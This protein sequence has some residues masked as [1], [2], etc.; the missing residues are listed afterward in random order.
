MIATLSRSGSGSYAVSN[1]RGYDVWGS[2]RSGSAS[3]YPNTR[4]CAN[5]GH[6]QDDES[7]LLY[8][9]AR[10]YEPW[11]GR[12]VT[13][14]PAR[15][16]WN[17][18]VYAGNEPATSL[19]PD[20]SN[21]VSEQLAYMGDILKLVGLTLMGYAQLDKTAMDRWLHALRSAW[22]TARL[23]GDMYHA[24]IIKRVIYL[25]HGLKSS[26]ACDSQRVRLNFV[27]AAVGYAILLEGYILDI[28]AENE[29]PY[30]P[31]EGITPYL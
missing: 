3:G 18:F 28:Q 31:N 5:L 21:A 26:T 13:E 23:V 30:S 6:K 10:Y 20:G 19:D 2:V 8:V 16:G 24:N 15:D 11:T 4:Y 1:A 17:W 22:R 14:D 25:L 27:T 12:F 29:D 7:G 9:R